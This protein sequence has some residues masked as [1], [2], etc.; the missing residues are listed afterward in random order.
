M[1]GAARSRHPYQVLDALDAGGRQLHLG[2]RVFGMQ[3]TCSIS[4]ASVS[5]VNAAEQA[6]PR[7]AQ[8]SEE[9]IPAFQGMK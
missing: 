6:V 5:A 2:M 4:S 9:A 7:S 8:R 3:V 1:G